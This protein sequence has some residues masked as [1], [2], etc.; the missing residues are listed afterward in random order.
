MSNDVILHYGVARRSGRYP[1]GSGEDPNHGNKSFL[2]KYEE[3]RAKGLKETDIAT[4]M[5]MNTSQLRHNITWARKEQRADHLNQI[6]IMK[7]AGMSDSAIANKLGIS[8]RTVLNY[9]SGSQKQTQL[10]MDGIVE[11]VSKGVEN[12]GY[13]DVGVGVE[14]QLGVSRTRFNT[15]VDRLV[16]EKGYHI[17][18]VYVKRLSD[19]SK[20]TT[21][22]VL[23]K[24][25]DK[26]VVNLAAKNGEIRNLNSY[27]EDHGVTLNPL[28]PPIPVHLDRIKIRYAEEGGA[29]KDGL[30]E[31]RRG[32][33]DLDLGNSKYAQVRIAA[34]T[35][36]YIKG[37]AAYSD[38]EFPPGV[39]IIF[40]TNKSNSVPKEKALKKMGKDV[41]NPFGANIVRQK[42][43]LN[44]VNEQGDWD[45][46]SKKMSSQFLSKQPASL[47]QDRLEATSK[48]LKDDFDEIVSLTNPVVKKHLLEAYIEGLDSKANHLKAQG[49][50]RTKNHVLLPIVDIKPNEIYAPLYKDGERVVLVRH[51]HGGIF[52]IPE[53]VVNNKNAA[54]KSM[55]G[56]H[57]PDAVGIH[58]SV[59]GKLSGADFDGDTALVIPNDKG[60]IKTSRSLKELDGWGE[61]MHVLYKRDDRDDKGELIP[62]ILPR[63][64][65]IQMGVI[66]NLITDMSIKGATQS[67]LANAVRH[68]M[69]VIDSE[70]HNLDYK[71]SA[72]D[73]RISALRKKYQ[74]HINPETG[75]VAQG[76]STLISRS[77]RKVNISDPDEVRKLTDKGRTPSEI[78]KSLGININTVHDYIKNNSD[79]NPHTYVSEKETA[80]ELLYASYIS[81]VIGIK[82][83]AKK[84]NESIV[85]PAYSK[86]AAKVYESEI[87]SLNSK[88]NKALL[89]APKERQAQLLTNNLY[90]SNVTADMSKD[91]KKKL[92]SR[93]LAKAR[94]TV[95]AKKTIIGSDKMPITDR[96]WEAIQA[97]AISTT[98]LK[99]ILDNADMDVIRRLASPR[100]PKL[101]TAKATRAKTLLKNGYTYAEVAEALGVSTSSIKEVI[102]GG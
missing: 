60:Q 32:V 90:Y 44:I 63:T 55:I 83:E 66:S 80:V 101:S 34:G 26:E 19:P 64:K 21:M 12:S 65:Q 61:K 62:T 47:V 79:F 4:Q 49:L 57:S 6:T 23:S 59:A 2:T 56:P 91:D 51:P 33:D 67:E 1:W 35:N 74:T 10:Q 16:Q 95:G 30:I 102:S 99:Q 54:G 71:Q 8:E 77:K 46:W 13:L 94:E 100:E 73:H 89:N 87:K 68:S 92:R 22:K 86:E 93:S 15:V 45:T 38:L 96:E 37:M 98:K 69:V 70:K 9:R 20:F 40:N 27:S 18:E 17:H 39:D 75:K 5:G 50:P 41:D 53:L 25:S 97:R 43:S 7:E 58:P 78:A 82:N 28:H 81:K 24:E 88:L 11:A 48:H 3:L 72:R 29:D 76:A 14:R 85:N 31:M 42:G 36:S 52:E 84:I